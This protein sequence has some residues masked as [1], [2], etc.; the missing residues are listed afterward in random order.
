MANFSHWKEHQPGKNIFAENPA[1]IKGFTG[2]QNAPPMPALDT[3]SLHRQDSTGLGTEAETA[4]R[5]EVEFYRGEAGRAF[6]G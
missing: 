3:P 5:R 4:L 6:T 2:S 1:L